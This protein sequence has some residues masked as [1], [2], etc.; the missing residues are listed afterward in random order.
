M[1]DIVC[2]T[3]D[4]RFLFV[5]R[6]RIEHDKWCEGI[7]LQRDP[8]SPYVYNWIENYA[9]TYRDAWNNS[10]CHMCKNY[11]ECGLLVLLECNKHEK[12]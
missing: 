6:R 8:G 10:L 12:Y 3:S 4:D 1:E 7:R 5:Q 9:A 11:R 2:K